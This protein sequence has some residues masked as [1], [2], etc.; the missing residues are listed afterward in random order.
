MAEL[1]FFDLVPSCALVSDSNQELIN[2]YRV[3]RD[4][5]QLLL[6]KL[7]EIPVNEETFYQIRETDPSTLDEIDQAARLIYL[8]KTCYNGLYRVNKQGKFNTPFGKN[9]IVNV[10]KSE[11]ILKASVALKNA[12]LCCDDFER[13]LLDKVGAED[14]V[15]LDPPYPPVG[16]YADFTRYTRHFFNEEDHLRLSKA[17]EEIDDRNCN[18]ILSNAN[19]PLVLKL[20]SK[21]RTIEVQAHRYINCRG[22]QRGNVSEVLVTNIR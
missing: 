3:V 21:F 19:H 12:N 13:V 18:F 17:V 2:A 6:Q 9:K 22:D 20:Y 4:F 7:S 11:V 10:I 8:N 16:R 14:F 5:P 1:F 15:Y